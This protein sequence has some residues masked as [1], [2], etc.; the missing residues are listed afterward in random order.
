MLE[1]LPN[2]QVTVLRRVPIVVEFIARQD[3]DLACGAFHDAGM[4]DAIDGDTARAGE[5]VSASI[6]AL[7]HAVL[8]KPR[9]RNTRV[10]IE[11][12]LD[13]SPIIDRLAVVEAQRGLH[14]HKAL[15]TLQTK[16]K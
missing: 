8:F 13:S 15:V 5:A 2:R 4:L 11:L 9:E 12:A 14:A 3:T 10:A 6:V 1:A 7:G 16:Q